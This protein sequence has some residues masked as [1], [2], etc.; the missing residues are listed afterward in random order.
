[1]EYTMEARTNKII[2]NCL[3]QKSKNPIEIFHNI[4]DTD[5]IRI[6]GPEH[7][8]LDGAALLTAFYNAGG[9]IDLMQSLEE[10]VR[11]GLQMPGAICGQWGVCG[12]VS[13]MGAALAII[14][15]TGPLSADGTWGKHMEFTSKA[16]AALA[17]VG[18]PRCCKRDAF[19]SFQEAI[20]FINNIYD[21]KLEK[22]HVKCGFSSENQQC[23][24][25][26]CPFYKKKIAFICVHNSCRSQ[27]AEALGKLYLSDEFECYS[28]GT[29]TKP[30]MN[31]DAVRIMKELY[32]IDMEITQY[33][34]LIT[35]IPNPDI[36]ISM[37]CNVECP[38]IGR[39]FDDNWG[40]DDPTGKSDEEFKKVIKEIEER[41]IVM[42]N[43][44]V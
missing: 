37:G 31:Q 41:I 7:H 40:L 14:D 3:I 35:D 6:H 11:R 26:N 44:T 30:Q 9:A 39:A 33:S 17:K 22:S 4:A 34:K 28:A 1:M 5:C 36:A 15:G 24:K 10:L 2:E 18:G 16:L 27:I 8:I 21:V 25:N 38:F 13:S 32:D 12:A 43:S 19:L 42:K 23:I 29:E 20:D